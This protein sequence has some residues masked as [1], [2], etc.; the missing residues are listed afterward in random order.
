MRRARPWLI[1]AGVALAAIAVAVLLAPRPWAGHDRA[2]TPAPSATMSPRPTPQTEAQ[3]AEHAQAALDEDLAECARSTAATPPE[4]CGIRIP[5]GTEFSAVDSIRFRIEKLP[6]LSLE[7]EGS[8]FIASGGILVATVTGT[9]LDGSP[10][11][12]NY[13]TD[14][15]T[16][17]GDVR[18]VDSG[19]AVDVAIW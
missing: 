6:V 9:G 19:S 14:D 8:R 16:V 11:T 2:G 10:R 15:W 5:W 7:A 1:A 13:R 18:R 3:V 12:E 17:R 4:R